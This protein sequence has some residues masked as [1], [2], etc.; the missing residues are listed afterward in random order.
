MP[1]MYL[2]H[3]KLYTQ[4]IKKMH[5]F[6]EYKTIDPLTAIIYMMIYLYKY[7]Y[8]YIYIYIYKYIYIYI[9]IYI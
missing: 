7:I 6:Y 5:T 8:I 9:Y 1:W 3:V 4:N 2:L